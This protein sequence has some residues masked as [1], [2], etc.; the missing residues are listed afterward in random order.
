M[1]RRQAKTRFASCRADG[2]APDQLPKDEVS[3]WVGTITNR[4]ADRGAGPGEE[5]EAR[6]ARKRTEPIDLLSHCE[7]G[8]PV[9]GVKRHGKAD[10][11][12]QPVPDLPLEP[13]ICIED[14]HRRS[15]L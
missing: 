13:L 10:D 3:T 14:Q 9:G 1:A 5:L 11:A 15:T 7:G 12:E 6:A 2:C 8:V 4:I